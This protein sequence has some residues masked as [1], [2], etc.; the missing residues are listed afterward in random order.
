MFRIIIGKAVC[1]GGI[2]YCPIAL[3]N[4][5]PRIADGLMEPFDLKQVAGFENAG[6]ILRNLYTGYFP[7]D[8]EID[9]VAVASKDKFRLEIQK[10][11]VIAQFN[12]QGTDGRFVPV[13]VMFLHG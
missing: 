10:I 8:Q 11:S 6:D 4:K 1:Q 12:L 7:N 2:L 9:A 13:D 3:I 5:Q